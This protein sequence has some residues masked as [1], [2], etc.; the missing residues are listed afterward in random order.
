MIELNQQNNP[1]SAVNPMQALP[2]I[3]RGAP[4]I[5]P[6]PSPFQQQGMSG[7]TPAP[8]K[9]APPPQP[10]APSTPVASAQP[11]GGSVPSSPAN[12][13]QPIGAGTPSM[14]QTGAS[15]Q[16]PLDNF[17]GGTP[18]PDEPPVNPTQTP[19]GQAAANPEAGPDL[20]KLL[21]QSE[22]EQGQ[23]AQGP[24]LDKLLADSEAHQN[25]PS[26]E[27][28]QVQET[29]N[30]FGAIH[31]VLTAQGLGLM[32]TVIDLNRPL[33]EV[34]QRGKDLLTGEAF[35]PGAPPQK[36]L[37]NG[38]IMEMAGLNSKTLDMNSQ[39]AKIGINSAN[40]FVDMAAMQAM[41]PTMAA[42][43]GI[44][45]AAY[46][47]RS[48]GHAMVAN[49]YIGL[50]ADQVGSVGT[51]LGEEKGG[52]MGGFVGGMV[53]S[54]GA[55]LPLFA[56]K[57]GFK[58]TANIAQ[59]VA[60]VVDNMMGNLGSKVYAKLADKPYGMP[61][62]S[63]DILDAY[64][65]TESAA[66]EAGDAVVQH[67]NTYIKAPEGSPA[68]FQA[69]NDWQAAHHTET[70]AAKAA[71]EAFYAIP[72]QVR[73]R[74]SQQAEAIRSATAEIVQPGVFAQNQLKG[75]RQAVTD[76]INGVF[77]S[78]KSE[79]PSL[80]SQDYSA[81]IS[82]GLVDAKAAA[83]GIEQKMWARA[84]LG[85]KMSERATPLNDLNSYAAEMKAN[86]S[87]SQVP[88]DA[89]T[90]LFRLFAPMSAP[91]V[92]QPL[93]TL[94]R[95]KAE[96]TA[97]WKDINAAAAAGVPDQQLVRNGTKLEGLMNNWMADSFPENVPLQQAREF[98]RFK[99]ELFGQ[100]TTLFTY[101]QPGRGG[102]DRVR[103]ED[104]LDHLMKSKHGLQDVYAMTDRL[105]STGQWGPPDMSMAETAVNPILTAR[106]EQGVRPLDNL[107]SPSVNPIVRIGS[108]ATGTRT[109]GSV[110]GAAGPQ[111]SND[112]LGNTAQT[113]GD[114][115]SNIENGIKQ[116]FQE[117]LQASSSAMTSKG[118]TQSATQI[119]NDMNNVVKKWAPHIKAF[120]DV[121]GELQ[122]ATNA[123]MKGVADRR[124][125]EDSALA[126]YFESDD[127]GRAIDGIWTSG[128]PAGIA[129]ALIT[130]EAGAG[131]FAKD[132]V[133]LEGFRSALVDKLFDTTARQPEKIRLALDNGATARLM[134]TA[135]GP[136]RF[137]RLNNLVNRAVEMNQAGRF[138]KG[139]QA[140]VFAAQY[141]S[142]K[143]SSIL[144]KIGEGG[145]LKQAAIFSHLA[146]EMAMHIFA[147]QDPVI[148]L[149]EA[150][151]NPA[152]ERNMWS[153]VP[154]SA[155]EAKVNVA[156]MKRVLR[157]DS[158]VR[159]AYDSY[160]KYGPNPD[161]I[162]H[163]PPLSQMDL[164][165]GRRQSVLD[166]PQ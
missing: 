73:G 27:E 142:L 124:A 95:V 139:A 21:A 60:G 118:E 154:D 162:D 80:T 120:A 105:M 163:R 17:E 59:R 79:D 93:P 106:V 57:A 102:T 76:R 24:D 1:F 96:A 18:G 51:T 143:V 55:A 152:I 128:N 131:G 127:V 35:R 41:A 48:L 94:Q 148:M 129:K 13:V 140:M 91:G 126:K 99:H 63:D 109:G 23:E 53:G 136:D 123:A 19:Q 70:V 89:V 29:A 7:Q 141:L 135:L 110:V 88:N 22:A 52:P 58:L 113:L 138:S 62:V 156:L 12:P 85:E 157:Y 42:R 40:A 28:A 26:A 38:E 101:L 145:E 6:Q 107:S 87:P 68:R 90:R 144:P 121:A 67:R 149:S 82:Q 56:A 14:G 100:D 78:I 115:R 165:H 153:R 39:E 44:T 16:L 160:N 61:V 74:Y 114:L 133:A 77:A 45:T 66:R 54:L 150:V 132:P 15:P 5:P 130:G 69:Y 98:S 32:R 11:A 34:Y 117:E 75:D 112:L 151:R 49:P 159:Q 84:P 104:V 83:D 2:G 125:I 3:P 64:R 158:G 147:G 30:K 116:K 8:A 86:F 20:D 50:V 65:S 33:I 9:G 155:K 81:R 43:A 92:F 164:G 25:A 47:T 97:L 71:D 146:K 10:P 4:L 72:E 119:A 134:E 161:P 166:S 111:G 108:T 31:N 122:A 137:N 37:S 46:L 103:P 36:F